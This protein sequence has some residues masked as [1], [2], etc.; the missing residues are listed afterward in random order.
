M[1]QG[2]DM[3]APVDWAVVIDI[4]AADRGPRAIR[5]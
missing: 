4:L 1:D 5:G 2:D 3:P